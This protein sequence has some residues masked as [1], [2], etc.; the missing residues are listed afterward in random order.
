MSLLSATDTSFS[1]P[2]WALAATAPPVLGEETACPLAAK[3][4]S[5]P[6]SDDDSGDGSQWERLSSA[7]DDVDHCEGSAAEQQSLFYESYPLAMRAA[8]LTVVSARTMSTQGGSTGLRRLVLF[9]FCAA[10]VAA[11]ATILNGPIDEKTAVPTPK[12]VATINNPTPTTTKV[13]K[14]AS[15]P[16][17][18]HVSSTQPSVVVLAPSETPV[19]SSLPKSMA[20][21]KLIPALPRANWSPT[22]VIDQAAKIQPS[23]D[24]TNSPPASEQLLQMILPESVVRSMGLEPSVELCFPRANLSPMLVIDQAAKLQTSY[25]STNSPPASEQLLQMILPES[26]VRSM[27]LEPSVELCFECTSEAVS[28]PNP[29]SAVV[30]G[31]KKF[32]HLQAIVKK[33]AKVWGNVRRGVKR[34]RMVVTWGIISFMHLSNPATHVG[35]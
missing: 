14:P 28:P 27:R 18:I 35:K 26:V 25:D 34:V 2:A 7:E 9:L 3:Q 22:V 5:V 16:S 10:I 20:K 19:P 17:K 23:Y 6:F 21:P 31:E 12:S 8:G 13:T 15:R 11:L 4:L 24:S 32:K 33:V 1:I 30:P 29:A